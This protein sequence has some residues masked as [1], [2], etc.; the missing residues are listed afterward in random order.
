[1]DFSIFTQSIPENT[2][3][4]IRRQ[5][6]DAYESGYRDRVCQEEYIF[7]RNKTIFING[8]F[9]QKL[10]YGATC[11][12]DLAFGRYASGIRMNYY[13]ADNIPYFRLPTKEEFLNLYNNT[14]HFGHF[15]LASDGRTWNE[16]LSIGEL[17]FYQIG[18]LPQELKSI[19]IETDKCVYVHCWLKDRISNDTALSVLFHIY[20]SKK[21]VLP[22]PHTCK[23]SGPQFIEVPKTCLLDAHFIYNKN[24]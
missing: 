22:G 17:S 21:G 12:T 14:E 16:R 5:I 6:I 1:M 18:L 3:E 7:L 9:W 2:P 24:Y 15:N 8:H 13:Q 4:I 20:P 11:E 23:I 19:Y 10:N